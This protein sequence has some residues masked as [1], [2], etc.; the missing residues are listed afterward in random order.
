MISLSGWLLIVAVCILL[1]AAGGL[2][3]S[4]MNRRLIH[5]LQK[6]VLHTNNN[7]KA[8]LQ[9]F[10]SGAVE[11]VLEKRAERREREDKE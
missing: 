5:G 10:Q 4:L 7:A 3:S 11:R 9:A 1:V 8:A 2:A 6:Q